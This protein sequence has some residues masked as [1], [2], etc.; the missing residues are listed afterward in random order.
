[1]SK[2]LNWIDILK[3]K[4]KHSI[5]FKKV[6]K[7]SDIII[8]D[9]AVLEYELI[10]TFYDK[11]FINSELYKLISES[12]HIKMASKNDVFISCRKN[13]EEII[14]LSLNIFAF[15]KKEL[16]FNVLDFKKFKLKSRNEYK[17]M[18]RHKKISEVLNEK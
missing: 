6:Y 13:L 10:T 12:I 11:N 1:M 2:L 15:S 18:A 7:Y 8:T 4:I 9:S 3:F 14:K 5:Y 17:S 16:L